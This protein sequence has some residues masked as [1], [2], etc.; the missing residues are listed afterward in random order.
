MIWIAAAAQLVVAQAAPDA[1]AEGEFKE[2]ARV[3]LHPRCMNCHPA[4]DAPLQKDTSVPHAQNV[5]RRI[6][7]VGMSCTTCHPAVQL[8][9]PGMPPGAPHWHMPTREVP[10]V[11]EKKTAAE[12]CEQL[13]DPARNGD[14]DLAEILHHVTEDGIVKWS[15]AP[16]DGRT[17]P[18]VSH[19]KFIQLVDAWIKKGAPCPPSEGTPVTKPEQE[20]AR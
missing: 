5:S 16:G 19:A 7:E 8:P 13:K 11:F 10:M 18:H 17:K 14:R 4:G 3:L 15:F 2:I 20:A 12:L 6:E 1:P 9:G